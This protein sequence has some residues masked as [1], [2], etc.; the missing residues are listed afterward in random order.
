MRGL[1]QS[2][3]CRCMRQCMRGRVGRVSRVSQVSLVSRVSRV[4]N[5]QTYPTHQTHPTDRTDQK[6][7]LKPTRM[8]RG[9]RISAGARYVDPTATVCRTTVSEFP[10]L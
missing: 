3:S 7:K 6:F 5:Y 1:A 4:G 9:A 8:I 2:E 10:M